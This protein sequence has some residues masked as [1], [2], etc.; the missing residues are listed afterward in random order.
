MRA[1]A[2]R[3]SEG[4]ATIHEVAAAVGYAHLA[5]FDHHFK[6]RFGTTPSAYRA[7]LGISGA[8][9]IPAKGEPSRS[10]QPTARGAAA[11]SVDVKP[12]LLD[13]SGKAHVLIVEDDR[14]GHA[15]ARILNDAGY[16]VAVT[17]DTTTGHRLFR[18]HSPL[19]TIAG[20]AINPRS[21]LS[22]VRRVRA[23]CS[24]RQSFALVTADAVLTKYQ[25]KE[26][27][28]LEV[29]I[30]FKPLLP[31]EIVGLVSRLLACA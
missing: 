14:T 8:A 25:E 17:A 15:F 23:C 1:A 5:D 2:T 11:S 24:S 29:A 28:E 20:S 19:V 12:R 9:T 7:Q 22:F 10:M 27:A 21:I 3:L 18:Q 31:R 4:S 13:S 30:A 26:L 6:A 16:E